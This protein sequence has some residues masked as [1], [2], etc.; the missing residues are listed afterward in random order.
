[1][2][3]YE[4]LVR[5]I[6]FALDPELAHKVTMRALCA[7]PSLAL[8]CFAPADKAIEL[9][10]LTFRN[11]AGLAAG[12]DKNGIALPA[13]EALGFGFAEIGTVTAHPQS[14]NPKPRIFRYAQ[15]QAL[16]NR[17]GFNNDGAAIVA[18]RLRQLR[19]SGRWPRIP[20]GINIGKSKVTP[21]DNA[22]ED[23]RFSFQLLREFADYVAINVSS[24]NTPGL[25]DLQDA[26]QLGALLDVLQNE[27]PEA[28]PLL[29]KMAPD[30]TNEQL[31]QIIVTCE[32]K[33][34]AGLIAT[35]TTLDHSEISHDRPGGLSGAPLLEKSNEITRAIRTRTQ[36]PIVGVGG[37]TDAASAQTKIAAGAQLI[38]IY[39]GL[40]YRGPALIREAAG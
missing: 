24:P 33:G 7:A 10:G 13:W 6:V 12:F 19:E 21:L 34:V 22:R 29:V 40:I 32:A 5:P 26:E 3:L 31:E 15:Q 39:T 36:L 2:N 35:N 11:R 14:G 25:R 37:I 28:K 30:L 8:R 18:K 1:M 16:I 23:Y 9:F 38:Q 20:I 17:L 27:N 4:T